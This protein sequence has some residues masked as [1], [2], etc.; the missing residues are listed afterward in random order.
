M[1]VVAGIVLGLASFPAM[2]WY[3]R[4]RLAP[5]RALGGR[6]EA[7]V[8]HELGEPVAELRTAAQL[9]AFIELRDLVCVELTDKPA[10]V[11]DEEPLVSPNLAP[12]ERIDVYSSV[13]FDFVLL[14]YGPEGSVTQALRCGP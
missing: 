13:V 11:R 3:F 1:A 14:R 10:S 9:M 2:R 6:S 4:Y 12:G 7:Q 8:K 5:F